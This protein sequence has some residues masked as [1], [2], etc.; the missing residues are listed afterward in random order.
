MWFA[1]ALTLSRIP[2]ALALWW[3]WGDSVWSIA[4]IGLAALSDAADGNVARWWKR[5]HPLAPND[6]RDIGDWLDP[7]VDKLFVAIVLAVVW[8]ASGD[9]VTIALV[10]ARELM[11]VP[12]IAVYLARGQPSRKL[13]ADAIGKVATI[14]Q[15]VALAVI[16]GMPCYARPTAIGCAAIGLAAAFHYVNDE[17]RRRSLRQFRPP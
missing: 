15:F 16:A 8:A 17:L 7:A 13:R 3:A 12:L 5:R 4:L 14:A 2:I 10:G 11:L 1:H 9:L 6:H